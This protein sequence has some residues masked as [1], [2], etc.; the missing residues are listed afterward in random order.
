MLI[1]SVD[2]IKRL[3]PENFLVS[4]TFSAITSIL[5]LE[6]L[7]FWKLKKLVLSQIFEIIS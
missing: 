4:F 7:S 1:N 6:M 3:I 2:L 5:S